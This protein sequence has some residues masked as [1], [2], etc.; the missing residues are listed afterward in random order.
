[1]KRYIESASRPKPEIKRQSTVNVHKVCEAMY[2]NYPTFVDKTVSGHKCKWGGHNFIAGY[3][4]DLATEAMCSKYN[5]GYDTLDDLSLVGGKFMEFMRILADRAGID[6][7]EF[8]RHQEG[9]KL[10]GEHDDLMRDP[11]VQQKAKDM[12]EAELDE[13]YERTGINC[14]LNKNNFLI[15]PFAEE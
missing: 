15:V 10:R 2:W 6:D 5:V 13:V 1:M 9:R 3:L 12:A 4:D 8:Y 7:F 14:F 11:V